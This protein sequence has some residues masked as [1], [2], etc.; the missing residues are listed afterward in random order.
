[1]P[2]SSRAAR[3]VAE[4]LY[5]STVVPLHS[6]RGASVASTHCAVDHVEATLPL[7]QSQLEVG[8]ATPREVLRSP[9]DVK[10]TVGSS[11][12]YRCEDTKPTINQIEVVPVWVD[13]VVVGGP[14]QAL[15]GEGGIVSQEL[16]IA[17]GR[18]IDARI[19]VPIK[20]DREGQGYGGDRIIPVIA[21]V[22]RAWHDTPPDLTDRVLAHASCR[23]RRRRWR[24]RPACLGCRCW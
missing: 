3:A 2:A 21:D 8:T 7:V 9:L 4:V 13:G 23:C 15:V 10:D 14:R 12:A 16:G 11:T 1:M 24:S 17:V 20:T 6:G 22:H 18:Q 19:S 5:K